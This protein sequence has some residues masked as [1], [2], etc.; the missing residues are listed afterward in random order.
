V[1]QHGIRIEPY[2]GVSFDHKMYATVSVDLVD[3][4]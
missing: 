4:P 1:S 3:A 2:M